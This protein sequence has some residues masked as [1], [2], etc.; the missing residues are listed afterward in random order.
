MTDQI[1]KQQQQNLWH[2]LMK[3]EGIIVT[4]HRC[5]SDLRM[6]SFTEK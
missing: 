4:P 5:D 6:K 1:L 3:G 2:D